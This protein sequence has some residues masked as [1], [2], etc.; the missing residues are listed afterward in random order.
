MFLANLSDDISDIDKSKV[1]RYLEK[2]LDYLANKALDLVLALLFLWVGIKISKLIIKIMKKSFAKTKIE[3][4]VEGFLL[5]LIKGTLYA[6]VIIMAASIMGLEATSLVTILGTAGL[7]IGLALQ[8]SLANFAGGVL[9]LLMKPFKVG[10]Y[11]IENDKKCEGTVINIDIFYTKLRTYDNKIVV[12][13]NGNITANSIVNLSKEKYRRLEL[14]IGVAYSSDLKLVKEVLTDII[15][16]SDYYESTMELNVY[17]D[18]YQDSSIKMGLRCY[19]LG[20]NYW[21][22]RWEMLEKIKVRFD[23]VGIVIPFNQMEVLVKEEVK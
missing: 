14:N 8:G 3:D 9:I 7:A 5:S 4:S 6:V 15:I 13:P 1:E 19:V 16:T 17:V 2:V 21:K 20:E 10:D 18:S 11:I 12:I 22:A 23:E